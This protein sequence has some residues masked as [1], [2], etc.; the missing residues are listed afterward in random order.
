[1]SDIQVGEVGMVPLESIII[2]DR[3]RGELGD[4]NGLED[5]MKDTGLIS[6]LAVEDNEDM[7]YTL[8]AGERRFRILERNNVPDVPVRI[9]RQGLTKLERKVIEKSENFFRKDMEYWEL[10]QLTAE[11]HNMQQELHGVKAPGPGQSGWG[12]R[13]TAE[14]MGAKSPAS[15]VESVKRASAREAFPELFINCKT[16][17]DAS[18]IIKKVDE[19][20]IKHAI[21]QRL[22]SQSINSTIHDLSKRFILKDFFAGVKE[23]PD[24]S[25]NFVEIDPPY[26]IDLSKQ[27]RKAD[28]SSVTHYIEGDYNEV[29]AEKYLD[30]MHKT[31]KECFR[32]MADNSW[33]ICW[34]APEPWFCPVY[35]LLNA[36]GF[37]TTRMC[38]E[39]IKPS[40]QTLNPTIRLPNTYEMF[41]YAWKGRPVLNKVPGTN[42]FHHS[43]IPPNQKVHPTERPISLTSELYE[44]FASPGSRVL[45]PF[46]G[47][48]NGLISAH[49]LGMD[50]VGFELS[51]AYK[52]SFLVKVHNLKEEQT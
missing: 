12:T 39:W 29:S 35:D 32:V 25:I 52:D 7:T 46:L 5:N 38:G 15:V 34:F 50:A 41:F 26:G 22:E 13:D 27:K 42:T 40:G 23:I 2:D 33:L 47:S 11:I 14:M 48:G 31:L 4:L 43:P 17:N 18:K 9:Y 16:A 36:V 19:T 6:P 8:L 45:I 30:F 1:M 21:A 37:K 3:A 20:L 51:K 44:I 24:K 49:L 28:G 10:D